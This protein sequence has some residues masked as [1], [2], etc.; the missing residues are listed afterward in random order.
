[1]EFHHWK[2]HFI[3][4]KSHFDHLNWADQYA[5]TEDEK[6][7]ITS[8][9]QQFQKGESSE[10]LHFRRK[11]LQYSGEVED[12]SYFETVELFIKEE[13]RHAD[14][15]GV[16]MDLQ[17]IPRIKSHWLDSAFRAI[18]KS[19]GLENMV[20]TLVTAEI[21]A[22]VYYGALGDATKS[23]LLKEICRQILKDED[24]HLE[25]QANSI[26]ALQR[27]KSILYKLTRKAMHF[28]LLCGTIALVWKEHRK[29]FKAGGYSFIQFGLE[30]FEVFG[31]VYDLKGYYA[32]KT[33][34]SS[35]YKLDLEQ[36]CS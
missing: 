19:F 24:Y 25:F 7:A 10:A 1:M 12:R 3:L 29:V 2:N 6:N 28:A 22:A 33:E 8:S 32:V 27:N 13:N 23:P 31:R 21:I 4:N 14:T 9:I 26:E 17:N 5:L 11:A 16:F 18:R 15:L 34:A 20:T 36:V 35:Y 30:S